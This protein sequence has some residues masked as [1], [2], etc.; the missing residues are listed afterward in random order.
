MSKWS[1][2]Y[3]ALGL[4][5]MFTGNTMFWYTILSLVGWQ[6][7]VLGPVS[8]W[9]GMDASVVLLTVGVLFGRIAGMMI[10]AEG[11]APKAEEPETVYVPSN[12]VLEPIS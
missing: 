4:S 7:Y 11:Y 6:P 8:F 5:G 1:N 9:Y 12:G 10:L 3:T 2:I